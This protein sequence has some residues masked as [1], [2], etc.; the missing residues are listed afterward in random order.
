MPVTGT[1]M[2]ICTILL[3]FPLLPQTAP[4]AD[5]RPYNVFIE[6]RP[7]HNVFWAKTEDDDYHTFTSQQLEF[8]IGYYPR[9]LQEENMLVYHGIS[10]INNRQLGNTSPFQFSFFGYF[11]GSEMNLLRQRIFGDLSAGLG[12]SSMKY[13][14][15]T[16]SSLAM[17]IS[18]GIGYRISPKD[19]LYLNGT[20]YSLYRMG[21]LGPKID[22]Q[23]TEV[24]VLNLS[25]GM[26]HSF[27]IFRKPPRATGCITPG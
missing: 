5:P 2:L 4:A 13:A 11:A 21:V 8:R 24:M 10:Y 7:G 20:I 17:S 22:G 27:N 9:S 3:S 6:L 18:L 15:D 1:R 26:R 19:C 25:L 14:G 23:D 16:Q 12:I